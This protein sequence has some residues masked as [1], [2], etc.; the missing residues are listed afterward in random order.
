MDILII[1]PAYNEAQFIAECLDSLL[2]QSILPKKIIVVDDGSTDETPQILKKYASENQI[3]SVYTKSKSDEHQPGAKIIEAFQFGLNQVDFSYDVLCKYDADLVFPENYLEIMNEAYTKNPNLGMFGG[4]CSIQ[5]GN[6]WVIEN[7]TN[8]DHIRGALKSYRKACFDDIGGLVTAMGWDTI[9]EF[10][11]RFRNW[12]VQTTSELVV[13]H[14]KPTG[15]SYAKSLPKRFGISLFQMRYSFILASITC[16]KMAFNKKSFAFAN[17]SI[18]SFLTANSKK[19]PFLISDQEGKFIR[20][21]RW[22][23]IKSKLF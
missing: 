17:K 12:E 5:K 13:K 4:I 21:Y 22:K 15:H 23:N 10:Q 3:I 1:I 2:N 20:N 7:L 11:A 18:L 14:R 8:Q 16:I 9:D 19:N 6:E